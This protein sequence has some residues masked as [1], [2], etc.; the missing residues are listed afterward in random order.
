MAQPENSNLH[1]ALGGL[2]PLLREGVVGKEDMF[3]EVTIFV[4]S[5]FSGTSE[6]LLC[7]E[8]SKWNYICENLRTKACC[9]EVVTVVQCR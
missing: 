1:G 5:M 8:S 3:S 6:T 9:E 2:A 4:F 7:H